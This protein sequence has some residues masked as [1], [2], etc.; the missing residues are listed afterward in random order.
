[1]SECIF[2]SIIEQQAPASVVFE[3]NNF[4][5]LMDAYPLT[6]GH[7][8]VIPKR[9]VQRLCELTQVE[10]QQLFAL[11]HEVLEAQKRSGWGQ[12]GGNLLL[13]DGK[14]ANQ[15]VPHIHLHLIPRKPNDLLSALP[16]LALHI[17]GLFGF[18]IN[19][20]KLDQ[21]AQQL[22]SQFC[23]PKSSASNS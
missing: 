23:A 22:A 5:V 20:G 8:L 12:A 3:D 2:C 7:T 13:N 6:Q 11:G 21:Q 1:M 10:Q 16:K 14:A 9:H 15:T 4:M 19:R 18:G 17:T